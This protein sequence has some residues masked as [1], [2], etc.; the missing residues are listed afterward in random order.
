M[1][2]QLTAKSDVYSFGVVL[3]E[4]I[5]GRRVIDSTRPRG[6]VNLVSWV[7]SFFAS[8]TLVCVVLLQ[9]KLNVGSV[10]QVLML[11]HFIL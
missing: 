8:T 4:L 2:G 5:T 3:L 1:T 9:T 6:E 10:S 7:R 11:L